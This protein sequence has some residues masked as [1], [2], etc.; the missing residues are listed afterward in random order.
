MGDLEPI[1]DISHSESA[2][3]S[4]EADSKLLM[5]QPKATEDRFLVM[6]RLRTT[7]HPLCLM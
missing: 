2:H 5:I 7:L 4:A 3:N 1:T 6:L